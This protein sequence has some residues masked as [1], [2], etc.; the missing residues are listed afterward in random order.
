MPTP[1]KLGGKPTVPSKPQ[2]K[3]ATVKKPPPPPANRTLPPGVK[4]TPM[5]PTN[6]VV[7]QIAPSS[8]TPAELEALE[9]IGWTPDI[10]IPA[11][12]ADA[13]DAIKAQRMAEQIAPPIDP[14]TPKLEIETVPIEQLSDEK[15]TELKEVMTRMAE[16]QKAAML[17]AAEEE[18]LQT[19]AAGIPGLAEAVHLANRTTK[20]SQE[21]IVEVDVVA[22]DAAKPASTETG[23]A[24]HPAN[25]PNCGHDMAQTEIPE[26]P[27]DVKIAFLHC[28]LGQKPFTHRYE[29]FNGAASVIF[30]TLTLDEVEAVY[31]QTFAD[32][33]AGKFPTPAD[34]WEQLNRYRL[35]LQLQQFRATGP[36]GVFHDLPDGLSRETN[37]E[38]KVT[39]QDGNE[40]P[41][42]GQTLLPMIQAHVAGKVLRQEALFRIV[43]TRCNEFN[44]MAARMEA[45]ADNADF[46]KPTAG[47]SSPAAPPATVG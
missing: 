12:F 17:A 8:L 45:M 26:P 6:K 47:Q 27:Y 42:I 40:P 29:L 35:F 23:A 43:H 15:R 21:P 28:L 13:F 41:E 16:E 31:A 1:V 19:K 20:E 5:L 33:K 3:P 22:K 11:D 30:R 24:P 38:A 46:W 4:G 36:D 44:R 18:E 34:Y 39:W 10:P 9:G 32:E 7:G 2:P 25:C 37:P 14:R